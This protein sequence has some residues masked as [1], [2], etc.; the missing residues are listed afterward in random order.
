MSGPRGLYGDGPFTVFVPIDRNNSD[1]SVCTTSAV[2]IL[3]N[4]T[5]EI[6][7]S[8]NF[9]FIFSKKNYMVSYK[10]NHS[11]NHILSKYLYV[12]HECGLFLLVHNMY[13]TSL[14]DCVFMCL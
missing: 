5:V 10:W 2:C 9:L 14:I 7:P 1:S 3:T 11:I 4:I 12:S 13:C 6:L 8:L